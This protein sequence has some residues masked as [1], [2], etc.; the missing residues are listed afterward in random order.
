MSDRRSVAPPPSA[1]RLSSCAAA[2]AKLEELIATTKEL[3]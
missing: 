2:R 3:A 1:V